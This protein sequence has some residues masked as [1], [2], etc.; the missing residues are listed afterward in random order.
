MPVP[1]LQLSTDASA[2]SLYASPAASLLEPYS[3]VEELGA[4]PAAEGGSSR[5]SLSAGQVS[6]GSHDS[7]SSSGASSGAVA[8]SVSSHVT[9]AAAEDCLSADSGAALDGL[10]ALGPDWAVAKA[11]WQAE[12][13]AVVG[14]A[15]AASG[16]REPGCRLSH[17]FSR[18]QP[19]TS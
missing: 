18:A 7:P 3:G 14:L 17:L 8:R 11:E 13:G 2:T 12:P 15:A 16:A 9:S 1:C 6:G 10:Q 4:M 5:P 19:S